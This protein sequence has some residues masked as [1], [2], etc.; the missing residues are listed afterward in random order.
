MRTDFWLGACEPRWLERTNVP[1]FLPVHRFARCRRRLPKALGPWALDSGGF[2]QLN[3]H[4]RWPFT[5]LDYVAQ[6]QRLRD[7]VGNLQWAASMDWMCEPVVLRKTGLT[8]LDHQKRTIENYERLRLYAPHLPF[9]PVLQGW[10]LDDYLRHVDMYA[11]AHIDLTR[12]RLVGIGTVCRRQ[13][14][15][16]AEIIIQR[17]AVMGI[18]LHGFGFKLTGL[19]RVAHYLKSA[20]SMAWSYDARKH[21]PLPGCTHQK[22]ANCLRYALN[23]RERAVRSFQYA[24]RQP[25]QM[26]LQEA[27]CVS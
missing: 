14:T 25:R 17:L 7:Q 20:D 3:L 22:C 1:L 21:T 16:D 6:V 23:W 12:E 26:L 8:V 18:P 10:S 27:T 19:R 4:G 9:I 2:T 15:K 13:G 24:A 11:A 5:A